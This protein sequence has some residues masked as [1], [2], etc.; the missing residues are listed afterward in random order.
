MKSAR[1][2]KPLKLILSLIA[3][4]PFAQ[5]ASAQDSGYAPPP[6]FDD[7][8][9][10]MVRP[11]TKNGYIVEP[12]ASPKTVLPPESP[13]AKPVIVPRVSVDPNSVK[14]PA[15]APVPGSVT[16]TTKTAPIP[17]QP[18]AVPVAPTPPKKMQ[19][20]IDPRDTKRPASVK[21]PE[22]KKPDV[23]KPQAAAPKPPVKPDVKPPA[24]K[25]AAKIEASV[26]PATPTPPIP[27]PKKAETPPQPTP[28]APEPEAK[29][30]EPVKRDP[31]ESAIQGPKTMPALP[32]QEVAK[33]KTFEAKEPVQEETIL[34]RQQQEAKKEEIKPITPAPKSNVA[35]ASFDKNAQGALKRSISFTQ[36]QIGLSS[37]EIDPIAVAVNNE[38]DADGKEDWRVQ[39]RAYATPYG[40]GVSS[41]KRIALSR[42]LSLRTALIA[43]GVPAARIDVLAEGLQSDNPKQPDRIDLYM[44]GPAS[45]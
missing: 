41:D 20:I 32:T 7:M 11:E 1:S 34:Q 43:Q 28:I 44:Y 12:K 26:V 30:I 37:A 19:P 36:G 15:P 21:K 45:D 16:T 17:Q 5:T 13:N 31:K 39:I 9:P 35:P 23:K 24:I 10:P 2:S 42:A 29:T 27:A 33:Q 14:A 18:A 8:T 40:T 38:L 22:I 4:L 6:M 25:P 3:I